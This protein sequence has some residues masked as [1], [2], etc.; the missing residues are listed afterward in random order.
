MRHM[1]IPYIMLSFS[2]TK[3]LNTKRK[4]ATRSPHSRS[5]SYRPRLQLL[6]I[7]SFK[8][9]AFFTHGTTTIFFQLDFHFPI[10]QVH[11]YRNRNLPSCNLEL[12]PIIFTIELDSVNMN[13]LA[14]Y[15]GQRAFCSKVL[16]EDTYRH[17]QTHTHRIDWSTCPLNWSVNTQS[18]KRGNKSENLVL[19]DLW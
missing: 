8:F 2:E 1:V 19:L 9:F 7:Y 17:I 16:L 4:A 13:Q 3:L 15:I 18:G 10:N 12:W 6:L 11:P 5:Y 14:G